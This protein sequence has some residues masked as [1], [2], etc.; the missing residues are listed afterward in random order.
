[1]SAPQN[2]HDGQDT[3]EP[4]SARAPQDARDPLLGAAPE[5]ARAADV[6][7]EPLSLAHV[8]AAVQDPRCGAVV[9]FDGVVRNHDEG[10]GVTC[11]DYTAHPSA[12][13]VMT[14]VIGEATERFP[15][16]I[17][18]ALHRY[19]PLQIGDS[20]LV[21]A[22]AAPHRAR[23]FEACA[24]VVDTVKERLPIWKNQVFDDG[25]HEWVAALG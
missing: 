21:V 5:R 15:D 1:M 24:H 19:G 23:A 10:R 13:E 3:R 25:T 2:A 14:Q 9:T 16:V 12:P 17:V 18:A 20:A 11:L 22:V 7:R 4:Q 8:I 6:T